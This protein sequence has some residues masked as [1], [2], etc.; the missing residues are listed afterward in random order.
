MHVRRRRNVLEV[1]LDEDRL[2]E[3][4]V[5]QLAAVSGSPLVTALVGRSGQDAGV[6][7]LSYRG[8]HPLYA[9]A[10]QSGQPIYVGSTTSLHNRLVRHVHSLSEVND[11]DPDDIVVKLVRCPSWHA[12]AHLEGLLTERLAPL[13]NQRWL[14]GFGSRAQGPGRVGHQRRSAWDT[15]HP[16]RRWATGAVKFD[17]ASLIDQV[18]AH[19]RG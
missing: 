9:P 12:A 15:L 10:A 18:A 7:L 6:Y 4:A 11:F 19:L 13:W 17:R 14:A 1:S 2:T 5:E 16:G 3:R 8:D